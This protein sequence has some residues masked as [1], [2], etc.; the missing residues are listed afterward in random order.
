[1]FEPAGQPEVYE[2]N[3]QLQ[4]FCGVNERTLCQ[5]LFLKVSLFQ[6][7]KINHSLQSICP[8]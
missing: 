8:Q 1:M 7:Q 2:N 5:Q 4:A 3:R 6:T